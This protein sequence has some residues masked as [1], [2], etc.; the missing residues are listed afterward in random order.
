MLLLLQVVNCNTTSAIRLLYLSAGCAKGVVRRGI[1]RPVAGSGGRHCALTAAFSVVSI[2]SLVRPCRGQGKIEIAKANKSYTGPAPLH[3]LSQAR[4]HRNGH[5]PALVSHSAQSVLA[6]FSL[7]MPLFPHVRE[8][9]YVERT[10]L[11]LRCNGASNCKV[12]LPSPVEKQD[13]SGI[14]R[15]RGAAVHVGFS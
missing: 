3:V 6:V 2:S 10:P 9:A 7:Y 4:R 8:T 14:Y 11:Q 12:D 1:S 13:R 15:H 5:W